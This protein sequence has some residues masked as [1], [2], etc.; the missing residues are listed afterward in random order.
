METIIDIDI[1]KDTLKQYCNDKFWPKW[2]HYVKFWQILEK[3][4]LWDTYKCKIVF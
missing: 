4:L 2:D 3:K 1:H